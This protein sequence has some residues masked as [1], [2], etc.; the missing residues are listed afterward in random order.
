[1]ARVI[2][3]QAEP[4]AVGAGDAIE[5]A[6]DR[7]NEYDWEYLT[8]KGADVAVV[9]GTADYSLPT[10]YKKPLSLIL[11]NRPLFFAR[12]GDYDKANWTNV[13]GTPSHYTLFNSTLG[14]TFEL[15][16]TP[17]SGG[18]IELRFYRPVRKPSSEE[19]TLDIMERMERFVILEAQTQLSLEHG[20]DLGKAAMLQQ[21]AEKTLAGIL[22]DDHAVPP[23]EDSGFIPFSAWGNRTNLPFDHAQYYIDGDG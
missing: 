23:S 12:R 5:M 3:S 6:L 21:R 20:D 17:S 18:T 11:D 19:E 22:G 7:L 2:G 4:D 15:L 8:V 1:M 13:Q 9:A 14:G 16:P 10:L